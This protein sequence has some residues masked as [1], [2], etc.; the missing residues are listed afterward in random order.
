M[1]SLKRWSRQ[2]FLVSDHILQ[3]KMVQLE[4]IQNNLIASSLKDAKQ[5]K[6]DIG[7]IQVSLHMKL[8]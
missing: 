6:W 8:K 4:V 2:K 3:Y 7:C 5:L 1:G